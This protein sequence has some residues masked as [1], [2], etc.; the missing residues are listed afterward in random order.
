MVEKT[1]ISGV[2]AAALTNAMDG[3]AVG[4]AGTKVVDVPTGKK[5]YLTAIYGISGVAGKVII[6][7]S[8]TGYG[9]NEAAVSALTKLR[10]YLST[11]GDGAT[12]LC[13]GPFSNDVF[14]ASDKTATLAHIGDLMISGYL[15]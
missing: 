14:V 10:L 9:A 7:D 15:E 12:E 1:M 4:D 13:I 3:E 6:F 5:F 8:A 2:N 11:N